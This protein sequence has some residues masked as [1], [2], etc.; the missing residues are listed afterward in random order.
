MS[1]NYPCVLTG[2]IATG[3][4]TVCSLLK[5]QGFSIID[6]D[7]VARE[8]LESSKKELKNL[9][10]ETIFV[11]SEVDRKKL[12]DIIFNSSKKR[13]ELNSLIHPKVRLEMRRLAEEKEKQNI[14]YI[15]DIPLF[16]ESGEYDCETIVVVYTPKDIQLQRLMKRENLS[17]IEAN[18]RVTSQ[19]DIDEKKSRADWVIDNSSDLK[20]LKTQTDKFIDYIRERYASSKV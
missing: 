5:E 15:L 11:G 19:I 7:I 14:P 16:F 8:V 9:F 17:Q 2:G 1:F 20:H 4:S 18:K 12:A 3:K 10:G 6:A 13:E